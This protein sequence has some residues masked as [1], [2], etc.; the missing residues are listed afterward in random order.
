MVT[1][2]H[3]KNDLLSRVWAL[4]IKN[5]LDNPVTFHYTFKVIVKV[6]D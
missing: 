6:N 3:P 4:N 5:R 1:M 2:F